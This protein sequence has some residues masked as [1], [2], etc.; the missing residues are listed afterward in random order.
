MSRAFEARAFELATAPG[1]DRVAKLY[2]PYGQEVVAITFNGNERGH[3]VAS[4][5]IVCSFF[6]ELDRA[7]VG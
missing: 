6:E 1:I 5:E 3:L 2:Q 4:L 7:A